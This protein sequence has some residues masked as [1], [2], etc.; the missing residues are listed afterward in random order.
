MECNGGFGPCGLPAASP[1]LISHSAMTV[2]TESL[3]PDLEL[4][5]SDETLHRLIP[6]RT[7]SASDT[8][9]KARGPVPLIITVPTHD[10]TTIPTPHTTI[11]TTFLNYLSPAGREMTLKAS[12]IFAVRAVPWNTLCVVAS[13]EEGF[14]TS[15]V[16]KVLVWLLASASP[17]SPALEK[18]GGKTDPVR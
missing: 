16:W 4:M 12:F 17:Q 5:S 15:F 18:R 11:T 3:A 7:S 9:L 13:G 8:C 6:N 14:N 10:T 2:P 1:S